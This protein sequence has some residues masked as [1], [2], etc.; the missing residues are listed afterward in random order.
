MF[1]DSEAMRTK[2]EKLK[3]GE[4]GMSFYENDIAPR[5]TDADRGC[6]VAI[7]VNAGEWEIEHA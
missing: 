1:G 3:V 5:L 2:E 6:Y 4:R 7:D